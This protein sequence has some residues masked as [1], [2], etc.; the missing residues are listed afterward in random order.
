[1]SY[2]LC[3]TLHSSFHGPSVHAYVSPS[4]K[5][6]CATY[7]VPNNHTFKYLSFLCKK[8]KTSSIFWE[9]YITSVDRVQ[10]DDC[11]ECMAVVNY[12]ESLLKE[13]ATEGDIEKV[14]D[15]VCNFLPDTMK[16]EVIF[17]F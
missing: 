15:K 7:S 16:T 12:V 3:P 17:Q 1:M 14:L 13:N 9:M 8:G 5:F 10:A 2:K 11:P 4:P 6:N